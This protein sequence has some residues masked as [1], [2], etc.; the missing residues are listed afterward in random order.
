MREKS[1]FL[2]SE[3]NKQEDRHLCLSLTCF[4]VCKPFGLASKHFV[5]QNKRY[6]ADQASKYPH[7]AQRVHRR[8]RRSQATSLGQI[9]CVT[10]VMGVFGSI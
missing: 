8:H 9:P 4:Q 7:W 5:V 1:L 6:P 10:I 2:K 3:G